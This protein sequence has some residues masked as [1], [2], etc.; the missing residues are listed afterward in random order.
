MGKSGRNSGV[1]LIGS[2]SEGV[3]S[4]ASQEIVGTW[5]FRSIFAIHALHIFFGG[6]LSTLRSPTWACSGGS[7][8]A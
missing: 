2:W 4:S 7:T 1:R 8:A 5:P 6:W 3:S